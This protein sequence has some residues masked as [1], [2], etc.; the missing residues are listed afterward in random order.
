ME[1]SGIPRKT[2]NNTDN[3]SVVVSHLK[4]DGP[5]IKDSINLI[6]N[7]NNSKQQVKSPI[8][9][10]G[11][12]KLNI[13]NLNKSEKMKYGIYDDKKKNSEIRQE[14]V[15]SL[16]SVGLMVVDASRFDQ[17]RISN[18]DANRRDSIMM[19]LKRKRERTNACPTQEPIYNPSAANQPEADKTNI[20]VQSRVPVYSDMKYQS[21]AINQSAIPNETFSRAINNTLSSYKANVK[22]DTSAINSINNQP[23]F[24]II[25]T[26]ERVINSRVT[27]GA[28]VN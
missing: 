10:T 12:V 17:N 26:P 15:I 11:H 7:N 20:Y 22:Q 1:L 23:D 25:D 9:K 27:T 18:M 14:E 16:K 28:K 5:Y 3:E 24:V 19:K 4:R 2:D 13:S 21:K 6:A 8:S